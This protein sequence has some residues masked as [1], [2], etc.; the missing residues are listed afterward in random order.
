[1]PVKAAQQHS[2]LSVAYG[3]PRV[4]CAPIIQLGGR[5]DLDYC[6]KVFLEE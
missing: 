5:K 3:G 1:M 6:F 2:G 4:K